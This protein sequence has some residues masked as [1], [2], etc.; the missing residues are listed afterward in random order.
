MTTRKG[1]RPKKL[2]PEERRLRDLEYQGEA[3]ERDLDHFFTRL[4]H[5]RDRIEVGRKAIKEKA[6]TCP[7]CGASL[8]PLETP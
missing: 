8:D 6:H 7:S 2:S 3:L 5:W 4:E 1:R